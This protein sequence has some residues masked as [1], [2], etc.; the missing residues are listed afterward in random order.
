MARMKKEWK[1]N[2]RAGKDTIKDAKVLYFSEVPD[3]GIFA[4]LPELLISLS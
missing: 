4:K 3:D 2:K 1:E